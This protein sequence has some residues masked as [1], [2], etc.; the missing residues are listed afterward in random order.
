MA[1]DR[2]TIRIGII[3]IA[4]GLGLAACLAVTFGLVATT[5]QLVSTRMVLAARGARFELFAQKWA[6]GMLLRLAFAIATILTFAIGIGATTAVFSVVD[7]I[8]FRSL[9]YRDASQLVSIGVVAPVEP[10]EFMLGYSYYEWQDHQ[11]PFTAITF[12][13]R[14]RRRRRPEPCRG[15]RWKMQSRHMRRIWFRMLLRLPAATEQKRHD[16]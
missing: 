8:L 2:R 14:C 9:P 16:C 10:Q 4:A 1:I 7:R 13:R 5:I 12:L 6:L 3:A 15:Y 11:T